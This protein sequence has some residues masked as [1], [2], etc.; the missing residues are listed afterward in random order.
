MLLEF[1]KSKQGESNN[2]SQ[3]ITLLPILARSTISLLVSASGKNLNFSA[4]TI[5]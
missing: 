4:S 5:I 1:N 3:I 2:E